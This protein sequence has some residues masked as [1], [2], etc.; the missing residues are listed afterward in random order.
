MAE[1]ITSH[2]SISTK[3]VLLLIVC[4]TSFGCAATLGYVYLTSPWYVFHEIPFVGVIFWAAV[5]QFLVTAIILLKYLYE[6]RL[7]FKIVDATVGPELNAATD[8]AIDDLKR[9]GEMRFRE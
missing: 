4:G 8:R 5:L 7:F 2:M 1:R 6:I 9:R 3:I